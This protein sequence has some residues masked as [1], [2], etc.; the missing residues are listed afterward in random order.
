MSVAR[1]HRP[2]VKEAAIMK[3]S[4]EQAGGIPGTPP[5]WARRGFAAFLS[6]AALGPP[7][8]GLAVWAASSLIF[9]PAWF[10]QFAREPSL[11]ALIQGIGIWLFWL[12]I[13]TIWSYPLAGPA[14][15]L[16]GIYS[17]VRIAFSS[18][19]SLAET[20]FLA[21]IMV[22]P[23][24]GLIGFRVDVQ[25]FLEWSRIKTLFWIAATDGSLWFLIFAMFASTLSL[26]WLMLRWK[27]LV[28]PESATSSCSR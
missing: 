28:P 27:L 11:E 12:L 10:W 18:W 3:T 16:A 7:L 2:R 4:P 9:I 15:I 6:V 21:A 13:C 22:V 14:A 20:L 19:M 8:G 26:R 25:F 17:G 5:P 23:L 24:P 1:R